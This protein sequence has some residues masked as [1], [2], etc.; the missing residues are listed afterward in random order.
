MNLDKKTYILV[1]SETNWKFLQ[2]S[3]LN[4]SVKLSIVQ[5]RK[6]NVHEA[7]YH[8]C[9]H[10][11]CTAFKSKLKYLYYALCIIILPNVFLSQNISL[12]WEI[13]LQEIAVKLA[14]GAKLF[15][16]SFGLFHCLLKTNC[17]D[18]ITK[19][20][21]GICKTNCLQQL[22]WIWGPIQPWLPLPWG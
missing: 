4:Q 5:K 15:H 21:F 19:Q 12:E 6:K 14:M 22:L 18:K 13:K 11:Q 16:I 9:T 8:V 2:I 17:S 20:W 10:P 1:F 7:L 3:K